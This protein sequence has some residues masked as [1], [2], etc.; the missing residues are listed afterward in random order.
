MS[1]A[2]KQTRFSFDVEREA[3]V[4]A[5]VFGKDMDYICYPTLFGVNTEIAIPKRTKENTYQ[6]KIQFPNLAP[7]TSSP[8][9]ILFKS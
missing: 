3:V 6:I 8:D 9:Y 2:E 1:T 5:D 4:Y 7:D